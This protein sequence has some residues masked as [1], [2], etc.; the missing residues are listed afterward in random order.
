MLSEDFFIKPKGG[1]VMGVR[2]GVFMKVRRGDVMKV[3][4]CNMFEVGRDDTMELMVFGCAFVSPVF[5]VGD[6]LVS[7]AGVGG[8]VVVVVV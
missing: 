5:P 1:D 8:D 4:R 7:L 2:R 3:R 6:I